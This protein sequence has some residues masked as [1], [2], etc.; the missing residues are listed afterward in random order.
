MVLN[1]SGDSGKIKYSRKVQT[2]LELQETHEDVKED[3]TLS[4]RNPHDTLRD[5]MRGLDMTG[6][7][8][9]VVR[10]KGSKK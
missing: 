6:V 1:D 5:W 4:A 8:K 7:E 2:L 3:M 10:E 9:K